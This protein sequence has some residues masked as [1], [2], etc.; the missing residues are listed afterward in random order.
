[1]LRVPAV[2]PSNACGPLAWIVAPTGIGNYS[3][4][5]VDAACVGAAD[6]SAIIARTKAEKSAMS[7]LLLN[8]G[9]V[10]PRPVAARPG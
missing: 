10:G 1:V 9:A 6:A 2:P 3:G 5:G 8:V 4:N 7:L